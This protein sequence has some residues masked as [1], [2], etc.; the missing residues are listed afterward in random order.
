M[1]GSPHTPASGV[2]GPRTGSALPARLR[3]VA[4]ILLTAALG[5]LAVVLTVRSALLTDVE[6]NANADVVQEIDEFRTFA[7]RGL[8]PATNAPF[9]DGDRLLRLYLERQF[10]GDDEVLLGW[11]SAAAAAG[12]PALL[13]QATGDSDGL[14]S[15]PETVRELVEGP[16]NS[17]IVTVGED[18]LRWGRIGVV[19]A[20]GAPGGTFL[21]AVALEPGRAAVDEVM[22]LV[23]LVSLGGL[24]L[25]TAIAFV[26][27][28]QILA[29]IRATGRAIASLARPGLDRRVDVRGR[30]DVASVAL[31][32]NALLDRLDRSA[33][34]QQAA[35]AGAV[36]RV[37]S[38]LAVLGSPQTDP[39]LRDATVRSVSGVLD[40]LDRYAASGV[41]G[42]CR[43]VDVDLADLGEALA[44][45]VAA[46]DPRW[47]G[48]G[49][50]RGPARLD[51]DLIRTALSRL[52]AHAEQRDDTGEA[53]QATWRTVA[54]PD[55]TTQL[56]VEV[57][58][59]APPPS[60][61]DGERAFV[62]SAGG[63]AD[64]LGTALVAAVAEAHDGIV[65]TQERRGGTG[66]GFA[67]PVSSVEADSDGPAP[68]EPG[69]GDAPTAGPGGTAT[70]GQA[71]KSVRS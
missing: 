59:G 64:G 25:V 14:Q 13:V 27:A 66:T 28:G 31:A 33:A 32:V 41:P 6:A 68:S 34:D 7:E 10:S 37:R 22:E 3:I 67:V 23:I 56:E 55:G 58:D 35:V 38:E 19:T 45:D 1:T 48:T 42:F 16:E 8:D 40:D 70:P 63:T 9:S 54:A 17:G 51:P 15:D 47:T 29:P 39:V 61:A 30:D 5:L 57:L 62:P 4:W 18:E 2:P 24:V 26:V 49:R 11:D 60:A 46:R 53:L 43:P 36:G 71:G 21:V 50:L 20:S 69:A 52:C 65:W 44:A 12:R